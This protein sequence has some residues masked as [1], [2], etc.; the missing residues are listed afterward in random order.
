M[1]MC[2]ALVFLVFLKTPVV[3]VRVLDARGSKNERVIISWADMVAMIVVV[4]VLDVRCTRW[5][6]G[7]DIGFLI[8]AAERDAVR[9]D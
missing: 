3:L 1:D 7:E 5:G 6:S 9:E 8:A 4:P 2:V